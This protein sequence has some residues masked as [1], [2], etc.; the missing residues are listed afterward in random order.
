M[1]ENIVKQ[2]IEECKE[3]ICFSI[4]KNKIKPHIKHGNAISS[5]FKL[6]CEKIDPVYKFLWG[7]SHPV[8]MFNRMYKIVENIFT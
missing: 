1:D 2:K 5:L 4:C 7:Q 8:E 6:K 3:C